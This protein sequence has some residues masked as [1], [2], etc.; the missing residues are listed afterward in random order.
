MCNCLF[1]PENRVV[2]EVMCKNVVQQDKLH[3]TI[4]YGAWLCVLNNKGYRHT[5]THNM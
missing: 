4:Q 2:D 1:S 3:I 5:H